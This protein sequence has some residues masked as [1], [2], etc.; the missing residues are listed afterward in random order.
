MFI[1]KDTA[2]SIDI[3]C[4]YLFMTHLHVTFWER[5]A[6]R[7]CVE[8]RTM[9]SVTLSALGENMY[10]IW[11]KHLPWSE[12]TRTWQ[13]VLIQSALTVVRQPHCRLLFLLCLHRE[14]FKE[15]RGVLM[16]FIEVTWWVC[17]KIFQEHLSPQSLHPVNILLAQKLSGWRRSPLSGER[18]GELKSMGPV[19]RLVLLHH[20][21]L[22]LWIP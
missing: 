4:I 20:G 14:N 10:L 15:P 19:R 8:W 7:L 12:P 5:E 17:L 22:P 16:G 3:G 1:T 18:H 11:T 2:D 13:D 21:P 6:Q 9:T